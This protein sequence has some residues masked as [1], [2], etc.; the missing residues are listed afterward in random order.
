MKRLIAAVLLFAGV[1]AGYWW[2]G[3]TALR[4]GVA[5]GL[6]QAQGHVSLGAWSAKGF[7]SRFDLDI[8]QA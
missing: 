2:F 6:E 4:S 7:P 3:I 5:Q 1:W 8:S